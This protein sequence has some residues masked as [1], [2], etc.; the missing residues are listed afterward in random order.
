MTARH[1]LQHVARF[2]LVGLYTGT[3]SGAICNAAFTEAIGR[4]WIDLES[5]SFHRQAVG[6]AQKKKRAPTIRI[7]PRVAGAYP[8][9]APA[10]HSQASRGR[11]ERR[12]VKKINKGFRRARS[13]AGLGPEVVPHV[14]RHTCATWLAQRRTPISEICGF[15]GMTE[16]MFER[17]YG[18]HH[19]DYQ[20]S[21]VNSLRPVGQF[22][23]GLAATKREPGARNVSNLR[24]KRK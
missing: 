22:V 4:G 23:G 20:A 9:V 3:R 2:I 8:P 15:L 16:E 18:H 17:V 1:T 19:P 10:R 7:P 11:M 24:E 12:T 6:A 13:I 14:L 21:A 5:G